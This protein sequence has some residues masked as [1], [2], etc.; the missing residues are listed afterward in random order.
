MESDDAHKNWKN[1]F[2]VKLSFFVSINLE[3]GEVG[4][5]SLLAK[6]ET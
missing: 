4:F 6:V 1:A 3:Y 5:Y 2:S